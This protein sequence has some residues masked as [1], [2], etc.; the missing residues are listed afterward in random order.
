[1]RRGL[2]LALG[3]VI[4][5]ST[6]VTPAQATD[7]VSVALDL[8]DQLAFGNATL[9]IGEVRSSPATVNGTGAV[10]VRSMALPSGVL[11]VCPAQS[12]E[13][14]R[15]PPLP[16]LQNYCRGEDR[17]Q[18]PDLT[19]G[20][21][22]WFTSRGDVEV[23]RWPNATATMLWKGEEGNLSWAGAT[24][25]DPFVFSPLE[26]EW[27]FR[28]LTT[29]T[30][31][32]VE[33][34]GSRG[35]YN[36]TDWIFYLVSE[37]PISVDAGGSF[38]RFVE[39]PTISVQRANDS[40]VRETLDPRVLLDLQDAVRG[41]DA[42]EPVRNATRLFDEYA[43]IPRLVDAGLLG[44][45]NGT[46]DGEPFDP[47]SVTFV[48]VEAATMAYEGGRLGGT[49]EVSYTRSSA[50]F[51]EGSGGAVDVPW[52]IPAV[53]WVVALAGLMRRE[54]PE[55]SAPRWVRPL[56][57]LVAFV[58]WDLM[59]AATI[60]TSALAMTFGAGLLGETLALLGFELVA[61]GLAWLLAYLP[62]RIALER[63]I[64]D[65]WSGWIHPALGVATL[66]FIV[67]IPGLLIATGQLLARL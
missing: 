9:A 16:V 62:G 30:E 45:L 37:G 35:Y 59:L 57:G 19:V 67:T 41:P 66:V 6:I 39:D 24:S 8:P 44:Y 46:L 25:S 54:R 43:R 14:G 42:R 56:I 51:S 20:G 31:I 65:Q 17:Y 52:L 40:A 11:Y 28:P 63:W 18:D 49:V 55:R 21:R 22:T 60:G 13:R 7:E 5:F 64:P 58:A 3:F 12:G 36:G 27:A 50:G 48:H 53:L 4:G 10:Q 33:S 1:M 34:D 29:S 2:I 61:F 26:R 32:T 23:E 15:I 38:G 47:A